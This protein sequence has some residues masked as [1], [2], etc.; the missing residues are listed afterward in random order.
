MQ[1]IL[2]LL[3]WAGSAE[4]KPLASLN[5]SRGSFEKKQMQVKVSLPIAG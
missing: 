3:L 1:N 2:K 4:L 5:N